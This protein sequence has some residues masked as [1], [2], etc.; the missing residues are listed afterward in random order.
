MGFF[1]ICL[2]IFVGS[3]ASGAVPFILNL[4]EK[5]L[6]LLSAFGAGLLVSTALAIILPEGIEAFSEASKESGETFCS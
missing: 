3:L 4:S 5:H 1:I 2:I 6:S